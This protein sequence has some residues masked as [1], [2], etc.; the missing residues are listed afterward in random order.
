L[1]DRKT[2]HMLRLHLMYGPAF[3][4]RD[5]DSLLSFGAEY[6]R[7]HGFSGA[8]H[9]ELLP[10]PPGLG[11][12]VRVTEATLGGGAVLRGRTANR[13]LFGSIG[14]T[15]GIRIHRAHTDAGVSHRVDPDLRLPIQGSWTIRVVG[16]SLSVVQAYSF[17]N[18]EYE[19]RGSIVWHRSAYR[20][21]LLLGLHFDVV[22][23]GRD[24]R[25]SPKGPDPNAP[26]ARR[27][28]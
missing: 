5:V 17:R 15:A 18:R 14:L 25:R 20:I 26:R 3:R 11:E 7:M 2:A 24:G 10:P 12:P 21:C 13:P 9:T 6:G 8:L 28:P 1:A 22:T 16:L 4:I 27:T 23:R 19:S